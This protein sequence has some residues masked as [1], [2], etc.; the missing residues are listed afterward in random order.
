MLKT[1]Q[2]ELSSK[3]EHKY[4]TLIQQCEK[5]ILGTVDVICCTYVGAGD[6]RLSK[7]K[8]RTVLIDKGT[9]AAEP[10]CMIPLVLGCK[11]VVLVGD[12]Q[13]LGSVIMNKKAA[14]TGLTQSLF[15]SHDPC[16]SKFPSNMFYEGTLQNGVTIPER[17]CKNV[18]FPW[19]VPDMPMSFYQNL[20]QE[21]ISSSGTSFLNRTEASNVEKIVTK[22]FKSGVMP[23]QIGMVTPYEGQRSYIVNYMQFNGLLK[24]DFYKEI[25]VAAS[26][27]L[28]PP[29]RYCLNRWTAQHG[30]GGSRGRGESRRTR[31]GAT[32]EVR[33]DN[34]FLNTATPYP[35]RRSIRKCSFPPLPAEGA[36]DIKVYSDPVFLDKTSEN[37]LKIYQDA[38]HVATGLCSRSRSR[39]ES[40]HKPCPHANVYDAEAEGPFATD[41]KDVLKEMI[42]T[43]AM[44]EVLLELWDEFYDRKG[45]EGLRPGI[46]DHCAPQRQ[47]RSRRVHIPGERWLEAGVQRVCSL[48]WAAVNIS[49]M[50]ALIDSE[51]KPHFKYIVEGVNLFVTQQSWSLASGIY[52]GPV[53]VVCRENDSLSLALARLQATSNREE[54]NGGDVGCMWCAVGTVTDVGCE[55]TILTSR[56]GCSSK[57]KVILFT[58][59][60]SCDLQAL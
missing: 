18:D 26:S 9:Q 33:I 1:E 17:L 23:G 8:F 59:G 2:G 7:L 55:D 31:A 39:D 52:R 30:R 53:N 16:L 4:K 56:R 36:D 51:G 48:R 34:L 12:H 21:E 45:S 10:E 11:E 44:G 29:F 47:T 19:P 40:Q 49:N 60:A 41:A 37:M 58:L 27:S 28:P 24:K 32:V 6:P 38:M 46:R 14:R 43:H 25:E 22:F 35:S 20:G 42:V 15:E 54:Y 57:R 3:D 5:E 13:H 50:A